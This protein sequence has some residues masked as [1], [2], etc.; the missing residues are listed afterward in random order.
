[1]QE[2][3]AYSSGPLERL[4]L[5][6]SLCIL[7]GLSSHFYFPRGKT[8]KLFI[9]IRRAIKPENNTSVSLLSSQS[10]QH[11]VLSGA[12]HAISTESLFNVHYYPW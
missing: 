7:L 6:S 9:G 3:L 2:I 5:L 8:S 10:I 4:A 12:F 1:M 11:G